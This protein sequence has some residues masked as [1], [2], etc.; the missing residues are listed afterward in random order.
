MDKQAYHYNKKKLRGKTPGTFRYFYPCDPA[1]KPDKWFDGKAYAEIEVTER[2]WQILF[3]LDKEEYNDDHAYV[4]KF[5]P[6]IYSKDEEE[7]TPEQRQKRIGGTLL[8][9]EVSDDRIDICRAM[10]HLTEQEREVY[11]FVRFKDMR[12]ADIAKKMG[13]TQ[14]YVSMLLEQ[15]DEKIAECDGDKTPDGVAWRYWQQFVKKGYMPNHVDV[16]IEYAL[17]QLVFDFVPFIHWFYSVSDLIR[18]ATKSYLFDNDKMAAEIT[19]YLATESEEE[20]QHFEDYYG[21]KPEII[22]AL[23]IRFVKE[24]RRRRSRGLHESDNI[25]TTFISMADKIAKRVHMT[26]AEFIDKRFMPYVAEK[27]MKSARQFYK[28]YT[29]KIFPRKIFKKVL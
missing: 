14:G 12:Q 20:R 29:G 18:F 15:A 25:Y 1:D 3:S 9:D 28:L 21:D 4:R 13:V 7:L 11:T 2:E 6:L 27:R 10:K 8:F 17:T 24:V 16:E 23:Y 22:G 19:D 5:T 26:T